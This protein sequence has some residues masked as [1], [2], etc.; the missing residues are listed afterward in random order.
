M[1]RHPLTP[2]RPMIVQPFQFA[3]YIYERIDVKHVCSK[4]N[5]RVVI[6]T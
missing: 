1:L 2:T 6:G 4:I 3:E 5:V